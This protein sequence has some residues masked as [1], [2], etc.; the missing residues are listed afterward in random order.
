MAFVPEAVWPSWSWVSLEEIPHCL[1]FHLLSALIL[2]S[3][4]VQLGK[5]VS[6]CFYV[7]THF[8]LLLL[9][10][11]MFYGIHFQLVASSS[12]RCQWLL[13]YP[14]MFLLV[15]SA[16][17]IEYGL[18]LSGS[19]LDLL[20]FT[21]EILLPHHFIY[22]YLLYVLFWF[23]VIYMDLFENIWRLWGHLKK[24]LCGLKT[25]VL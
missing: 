9:S 3:L 14:L 7:C 17:V 8:T 2:I 5:Y 25:F 15:P 4:S 21:M 19:E 23:K 20:G 22:C 24:P 13:L 6:N 1:G 10:W 16:G 18:S 12:E 11:L